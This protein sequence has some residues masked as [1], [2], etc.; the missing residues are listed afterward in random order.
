MKSMEARVVVIGAGFAGAAAAYRLAQSGW[1]DIVVLEQE[2]LP[3]RHSSG[4]NAAL[5]RQI[6]TSHD[7]LPLAV[8]GLRFLAAA[9]DDMPARSYLNA[10]GS[11]ILASGREA[12]ALQ[13]FQAHF[14]A[15][16]LQ[17]RWVGPDEAEQLVPVVTGDSCTG[18]IH[19]PEDGIVDIAGLL[20]GYLRSAAQR[21]AR[22]L[23]SRRVTAIERAGGRVAAVATEQE[24]I[25]TRHVV[26]AAG[27]WANDV[28]ALAGLSRLPLRPCRRHVVVTGALPWVDSAWP[29]VW[30]I[31]HGFYFRPEAPGL[32]LSPCDEIEHPPGDVAVDLETVALLGEKVARW[33]PRLGDLTVQRT[34]AG[35]RTLTPDG[36]FVI[37]RDPRLDGFVWCAGLGGHGVTTSAAVGRLA[38]EAVEKGANVAAHAPDRFLQR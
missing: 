11:L 23:T 6:I 38:A 34:W 2:D 37:G 7:L 13:T 35:L 5:G 29:F 12:E 15:S 36:N 3:G 20:D 22:V 33:A 19:C 8:E 21:G 17:T 25:A 1:T 30:D 14:V 26:N 27:A 31:S 16:G 4:R 28:A 32:L 10:C 18:G 9:A 24:R